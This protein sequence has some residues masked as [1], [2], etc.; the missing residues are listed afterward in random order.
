MKNSK[1]SRTLSF[2][3]LNNLQM[4]QVAGTVNL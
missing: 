2:N 1:Y 3:A 4:K